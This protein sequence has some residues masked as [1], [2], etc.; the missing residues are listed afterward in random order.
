MLPRPAVEPGLYGGGVEGL[1]GSGIVQGDGDVG[2]GLPVAALPPSPLS[3]PP[4]W[5]T[6]LIAATRP[7][8]VDRS[9]ST[10]VTRRPVETDPRSSDSTG[11]VT[12]LVVEVTDIS[13]SAAS[14]PGWARRP[15]T[16]TADLATTASAGS[17]TPVGSRPAAFCQRSTADIRE[18]VSTP[19]PRRTVDRA[20][21]ALA[22][23]C[24][25]PASP[26]PCPSPPPD[27]A[28]GPVGDA[29]APDDGVPRP[30]PGARSVRG[31]PSPG[32]CRRTTVPGAGCGPMS[33]PRA[34]RL[35]AR[36]RTSRPTVP[37]VSSLRYRGVLP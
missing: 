9:G 17:S 28:G 2:G 6:V 37:G 33:Y 27:A 22:P 12:V 24:C 1:D 16:R 20:G 26:V 29:D 36:T 34:F 13:S 18:A 10:T 14:S 3:P 7:G 11:T 30:A 31:E 21:P 32:A 15:E 4:P 23:G 8:V 25:S 5:T 19:S 35:S